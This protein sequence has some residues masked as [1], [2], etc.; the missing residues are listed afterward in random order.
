[1]MRSMKPG[2]VDAH[3]MS[4]SSDGTK[5]AADHGPRRNVRERE[6]EWS[7]LMHSANASD[8]AAYSR[9][10][11]EITPTL[12][13]TAERELV[14]AG[15]PAVQREA[16]VQEILLAVHLKRHTRGKNSSF[17]TW[18]LAIARN[19]LLS[20]LHQ[21]G[22]RNGGDIDN[23]A[24]PSLGQPAASV[25]A[26]HLERHIR[27]LPHRQR[28]VLQ[29]IFSECVSVRETAAKLMMSEK[30]VRVALHRGLFGVAERMGGADANRFS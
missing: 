13:A 26:T 9:L 7:A 24:D 19:K 3:S 22:H 21:N 28:H 11:E 12:R 14:R 30:A 16:I 27:S 6:V 4:G 17:C 23:F 20:A 1:M 15:L 18:L 25:E 10:L 8:G 2:N 5:C 29:T